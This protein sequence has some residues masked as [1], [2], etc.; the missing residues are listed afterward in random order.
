VNKDKV[1]KINEKVTVKIDKILSL[2]IFDEPRP[3][4]VAKVTIFD[5]F[6][7]ATF[8]KLFPQRVRPN[9][10]TVFRFVT[11]PFV[12]ILLI[13][14]DYLNGF[15]LFSLSAFSDALDGALARTRNQITDWGIVFDPVAD[16]LLIGTVAAIVITKAINPLMAGLIIGME[17]LMISSAYHRYR[18]RFVPAKV[19]AKIKMILQSVG[20]ALL[21]LGL[22]IVSPILLTVATYV[23]IISVVF[24]FLSLVVYKSI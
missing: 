24:S 12:A 20:V 15:W 5:R 2:S 23:L 18:G 22:L 7:A 13:Q 9:F 4:Y 14:G 6:F 11:I 3:R 17:I 16:K 10:L 21:L 19:P 1:K 8:L